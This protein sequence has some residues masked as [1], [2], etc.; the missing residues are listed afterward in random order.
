MPS[1]TLA[2]A[3]IPEAVLN[4]LATHLS[5]I[6]PHLTVISHVLGEFGHDHMKLHVNGT[7]FLVASENIH[8]HLSHNHTSL[9]QPTPLS[10][11]PS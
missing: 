6:G 4:E 7:Q 2:P 3:P 11:V 5:A 9:E 8:I 1:S 10:Q